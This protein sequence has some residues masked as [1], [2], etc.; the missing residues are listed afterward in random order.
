MNQRGTPDDVRASSVECMRRIDPIASRSR[1]T[2]PERTD[3]V[4]LTA[5][6]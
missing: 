2:P 1:E 4:V 5:V 6:L 3:G